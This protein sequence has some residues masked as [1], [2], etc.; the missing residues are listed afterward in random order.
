MSYLYVTA[1]LGMNIPEK[2]NSPIKIGSD[3][4]LTNDASHFAKHISPEQYMSIGTLEGG[5]LFKGNPVIYTQMPTKN[6]DESHVHIVNFMRDC[7]AFLNSLWISEDNSV[8]IELGFAISGRTGHVHSNSLAYHYWTCEGNKQEFSIYPSHL[9]QI[10]D[11]FGSKFSGM[12][13]GSEPDYTMQRK[14]IDRINI[15]VNFLQQARSTPDLGF[16]I[17]SY[18]SFFESVLSTTNVE[19]SHQMAERAAFY[20]RIKPAERL[21]LY[22]DLK[23]AYSVRSK[24]VHGDFISKKDMSK[25]SEIAKKCD[26]TAREILI[27]YLQDKEF[28]SA[29]DESSNEPL[30]TFFLHKIFGLNCVDA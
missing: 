13:V 27:K 4:Y 21:E 9:M 1:L 8:N 11:K 19:L 23:Q 22:K 17:A 29:I 26:N 15:G 10:Y 12:A 7:L 18:C 16:K 3:I 25:L 2:I 6:I 5:Y 14:E 30:D 20:L 28:S 24:V